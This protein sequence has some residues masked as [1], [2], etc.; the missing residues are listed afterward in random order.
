[1]EEHRAEGHR[2]EGMWKG[3]GWKGSGGVPDGRALGRRDVEGRRVDPS[4]GKRR[5]QRCRTSVVCLGCAAHLCAG[6]VLPG[7][8]VRSLSSRGCS[9]VGDTGRLVWVRQ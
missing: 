5:G 3:T 1:M 9:G 7:F 4:R 8:R 2:V 6:K